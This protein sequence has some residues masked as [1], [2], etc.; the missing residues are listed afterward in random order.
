MS[1]SLE[2]NKIAAAVLTAGVIAMTCGLLAHI[3]YGSEKMTDH[4]YM[5]E[6]PDSAGGEAETAAAEVSLASLLAQGDLEKGQ[7]EAKKCV[8]C[9][10]FENGGAEGVGPNL[11]DLV[12]SG[13]ANNAGYAY[14]NALA[15]R[16]SENWTYENLDA[17][18][19]S[20]KGFE[21]GTKMSFAGISRPG[22]R[23]NLLLYLRSLSD[24]PADLPVEEVREEAAEVTEEDIEADASAAE[25]DQGA[26][27]EQ[28]AEATA[29][30]G[31]MAAA[32]AAADPAAGEKVAKKCKACHTFD[33]GGASRI[34]PNLWNIVDR[35]IA[36]EEGF[37]YSS[38]M[39]DMSGEV[40]SYANLDGF[41]ADPKG[42]AKGT[43]MSFAGIKKE[44]QR[45]DLLAY[46]RSLSANPVPLP[47]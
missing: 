38:A 8:A 19:A 2:G 27:A 39:G 36:G 12:D 20:P 43:K 21:P 7:K 11:W 3:L 47:E 23:A 22:N 45:A 9:H 29:D 32:L 33:E 4:A 6:V 10:T 25:G 34:G 46:L 5:I 28:T 18:L 24:S 30:G 35:P 26:G 40:W 16:N 44:G 31:G 15:G 41:L 1:S 17:F 37:K 14:S 13:I 42:W